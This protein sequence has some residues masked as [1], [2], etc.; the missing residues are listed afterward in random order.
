MNQKEVKLL[1]DSFQ[2][3]QNRTIVVVD[4]GNVEKWKNSL[5]WIIGIKEL[6]QLVKNFSKGNKELRKFYYGSDYGEKES[7]QII[8]GWSKAILEKAEMNRFEVKTKRVK[9]IHNPGN[10]FGFDKKCNFDVEIAVD[11]IKLK[12]L[13]DDII[14]FS[15]DGDLMYV[16][17]YLREEYGKN[18]LVFGARDRVGREIFDSEKEH[19]I[20]D[21]LFTEEFEYRLNKGRFLK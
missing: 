15:G 17:R 10:K 18:C 1:L 16:I 6:G 12:D 5:G 13:Y 9:Y 3:K 14:L 20:Q 7:S 11:L 21:I 2:T 4:Y 8:S 19:I